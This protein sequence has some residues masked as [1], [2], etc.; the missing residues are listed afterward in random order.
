MF[1]SQF[2]D[3]SDHDQ[4][5]QRQG[6]IAKGHHKGEITHGQVKGSKQ[7][8]S[9]NPLF[10]SYILSRIL[11]LRTG[12]TYTINTRVRTLV[13]ALHTLDPATSK[14]PHLSLHKALGGGIS[15]YKA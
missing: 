7:V 8:I 2:V 10:V 15:R 4:M 3:V 5:A 1:S 11:T 9:N 14:N 13:P 12:S 6:G